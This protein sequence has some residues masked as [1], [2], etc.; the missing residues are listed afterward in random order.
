MAD[1]EAEIRRMAEIA[2]AIN[3]IL[4]AEPGSDAEASTAPAADMPAQAAAAD[5]ASAEMSTAEIPAAGM[6]SA[7]D[8][9]L[10]QITGT[11]AAAAEGDVR[12]AADDL[13]AAI[14]A[15]FKD[16]P[17]AA[18]DDHFGPPPEMDF[19]AE[20]PVNNAVDRAVRS[21]SQMDNLSIR[22]QDTLAELRSNTGS[23]FQGSD[24][25]LADMEAARGALVNEMRGQIEQIVSETQARRQAIMQELE[26]LESRSQM[27]QDELAVMLVR[28]E[29]NLDELHRR[30]FASAKVNSERLTRY[31][32]FLQYLLDERGL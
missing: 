29:S 23:D 32:E 22:M 17:P 5:M 14:A 31:R 26:Q 2:D 3:A 21:G 10:D 7:A 30:Y 8:A 19:S 4:E 18:E 25:V 20:P 13:D 24:A 6:P 28:F 16:N 27:V 11:P 9:V 12:I 1:E 15:E